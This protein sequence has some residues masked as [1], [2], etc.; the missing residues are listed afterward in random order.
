MPE[1][2]PA[3]AALIR[4]VQ[5][6][7]TA[8]GVQEA[9]NKV[10]KPAHEMVAEVGEPKRP[11]RETA[12][13]ATDLLIML[14]EDKEMLKTV[15]FGTTQFNLLRDSVVA[16]GTVEKLFSGGLAVG[17]W[18][19]MSQEQVVQQSLPWRDKLFVKA[20]HVFFFDPR[21]QAVYRDRN[22]SRTVEEEISDLYTAL[23]NAKQD[24]AALASV[25]FGPEDIAEGERLLAQAEGRDILGLVGI[26]N[27]TEM[28][29][30][31]NRY[32]TLVVVLAQYARSAGMSA[33]WN[34]PEKRAQYARMSFE[35]ALQRLYPARS[36]P[37]E[38]T[39]ATPATKEPEKV[40]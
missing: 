17:D 22:E 8:Q 9:I 3:Q 25:G 30:L 35:D 40:G 18:R 10:K 20:E 27:Q 31:R 2:T 4:S 36:R 24:A 38:T 29:Q 33:F 5:P 39:P 7:T 32:L 15:N 34:N 13:E 14:D 6:A 21:R 23:D 11:V 26:R 12:L 16:L 19:P 37:A 1:A 28:K